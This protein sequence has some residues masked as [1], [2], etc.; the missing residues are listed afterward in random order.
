MKG[1]AHQEPGLWRLE[2]SGSHQIS[3]ENGDVIILSSKKNG[4][5]GGLNAM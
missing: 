1:E 4:K 2:R 5:N 3:P